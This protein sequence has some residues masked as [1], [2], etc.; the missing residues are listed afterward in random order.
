[1]SVPVALEE[2]RAQVERFGARPYLLTVGAEAR[3]HAV[4]VHVEWN[5]EGDALIARA[6]KR[7]IANAGERPAVTLL[8]APVDDE[9]FSLIVDGT[10]E[11]DDDRVR[12]RP[13]TAVLHRTVATAG[14][15]GPYGSDCVPV[16][17]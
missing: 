16:L 14:P 11:V 1:M 7:T 2:L 6:G 4:S 8:W 3:P 10:A 12:V 15:S 13:A 9:G 17:R 5:T